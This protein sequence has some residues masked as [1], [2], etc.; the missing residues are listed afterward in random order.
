VSGAV[1][2]VAQPSPPTG[3]K[4]SKLRRETAANALHQGDRHRDAAAAAK[5]RATTITPL[6][7]LRMNLRRDATLDFG[8]Y[9]RPATRLR[10]AS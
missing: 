9:W 2:G 6:V 3:R 10:P 5:H 8:R 1:A 4:P 7:G